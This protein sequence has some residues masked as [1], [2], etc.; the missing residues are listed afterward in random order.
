MMKN[1]GDIKI[2]WKERLRKETEAL[3]EAKRINEEQ[4][5]TMTR[6]L[7]QTRDP[8]SP[9]SAA[10]SRDSRMPPNDRGYVINRSSPSFSHSPGRSI[11]SQASLQQE[12]GGLDH[13][14]HLYEIWEQRR[15]DNRY[16]KPLG[17]S[18]T[19]R[20]IGTG[21]AVVQLVAAVACTGT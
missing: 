21:L 9:Q 3:A 4:P 8:S 7:S 16:T 20:V 5:T 19:F 18:T 6:E 10:P 2:V 12:I 11:I 13:Q 17:Y 14:R 15:P 1:V